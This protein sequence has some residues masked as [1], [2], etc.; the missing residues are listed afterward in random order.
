MEFVRLTH[1]LSV[2]SLSLLALAT[3]NDVTHQTKTRKTWPDDRHHCLVKLLALLWNRL[4]WIVSELRLF[5]VHETLDLTANLGQ[6]SEVQID[7]GE[8]NIC[9]LIDICEMIEHQ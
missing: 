6:V 2:G 4:V 1:I 8:S 5:P 9:D 3:I 7:T